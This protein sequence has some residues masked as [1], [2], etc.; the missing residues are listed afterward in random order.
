MRFS[1][2]PHEDQRPCPK[3]VI[4][5]LD[6]RLSSSRSA[7]I[8]ASLSSSRSRFN[9]RRCHNP[10]QN[11]VVRQAVISVPRAIKCRHG[12][13]RRH[14]R[15]GGTLDRR[16]TKCVITCQCGTGASSHSISMTRSGV[17]ARSGM[18]TTSSPISK[19]CC[20]MLCSFSREQ[21]RSGASSSADRLRRG[22][23]D[24]CC[25]ASRH[26]TIESCVGRHACSHCRVN[27]HSIIESCRGRDV[28][29]HG[30]RSRASTRAN[31]V[32]VDRPS[33]LMDL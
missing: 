18:N 12:G 1:V 19:G 29:S 8:S 20:D 25:R 32:R 5:G 14:P 21:S 7:L 23:T 2:A 16:S 28:C 31:I 22:S 26:Q 30:Y 33:V 13:I 17:E 27:R 10:R 11:R 9:S 24:G 4:F 3:K 6:E 15:R